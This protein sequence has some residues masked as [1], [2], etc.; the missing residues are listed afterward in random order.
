MYLRLIVKHTYG[1]TII[2]FMRGLQLFL[3]CN[4]NSAG[5][6]LIQRALFLLPSFLCSFCFTPIATSQRISQQRRFHLVV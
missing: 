4:R 6:N 1:S 2:N 3:F 5:Y